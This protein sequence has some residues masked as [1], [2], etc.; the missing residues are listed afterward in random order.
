MP[1]TSIF[2][3]GNSQAVRI[4]KAFRYPRGTREVSIRREGDQIILE[5]VKEEEW[6]E[7][8]WS[9]FGDMPDGFQRPQPSVQN[10]DEIEF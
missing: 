2:I 8:F 1:K 6:P 4:P 7:D 5:A 3:S 10:R 9:A